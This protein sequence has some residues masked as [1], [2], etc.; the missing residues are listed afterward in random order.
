MRLEI[1]KKGKFSPTD[2]YKMIFKHRFE[3]NKKKAQMKQPKLF[4]L[5]GTLQEARKMSKQAEMKLK[6]VAMRKAAREAKAMRQMVIVQPRTFPNG[7][8]TKNGKVYDIAGNLVATVNRKNGKMSTM[9]GWSLGKYKPKSFMTNMVLQD[10]IHKFSPYY[11]NL[12]K[13]QAMQ[14]GES[15]GVHGAQNN[16]VVN[17]H[18]PRSQSAVLNA[19]PPDLASYY[20]ESAGGP[21]Q[22][23]GVTAW[24]AASDNVWGTFADNAWGVSADNVWGTN[25]SDVWGG[26]GGNPWG[27]FAKTVRI[28]GTGNGHNYLKGLTNRVAAFFGLNM[29]SKNGSGS[30]GSTTRTNSTPRTATR[31]PVQVTRT[32]SA[33]TTTRR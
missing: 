22:N 8:I 3:E 7:N 27:N 28:W 26:I 12:R 24:G 30:S 19:P 16:E 2:R 23:I 33:P 5:P 1:Q 29:K 10:T 14:G 18:G 6:E 9:S 15:F 11:I 13:M 32:P 25:S 21:R 20:G 4:G 31:A 17:V